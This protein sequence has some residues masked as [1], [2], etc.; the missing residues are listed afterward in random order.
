VPADVVRPVSRPPRSRRATRQR[1][2]GGLLRA[3]VFL[4]LLIWALAAMLP[5]L[6]AALSSL[7]ANT[8]LI[9]DPLGL[10]DSPMWHNFR[11]AWDGPRLGRPFHL[12]A[13]NSV[14]ASTVG[15]ASGIGVGTIAAYALARR[16]SRLFSF[17]NRYFIVLIA[18]P[19][20]VTWIPLFTLVE[21]LGML[22][23]PAALG[24]IYGA[25]VTPTAVI[26]MRAYFA[27]FPLDLVE[28]A[29]VDGATEV[30]AFVRIVLPLSKGALLA[31]TIVQGIFTWNELGLASVLLLDAGSRTLPVGMTLFQGLESV[32]RGA[33][34][35]S[36]MMM[37]APVVV[38]YAL[39][40]RRITDGMRVGAGL[41]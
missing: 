35:A 14:V 1:V 17:L 41:K 34:F 40:N 38:L 18:L 20:V 2:T 24:V 3:L 23:S 12:F 13:R 16:R 6:A 7:K 9:T 39:F 25:F 8:E 22:S 36:L 30:Q 31:V 28:A 10:P 4:A 15:L 33:Q 26:L 11:S 37:I 21:R 27:G 5:V 29:K 32:D 19:P